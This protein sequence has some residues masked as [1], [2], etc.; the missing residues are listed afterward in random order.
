MKKILLAFI[1]TS[2]MAGS[3]AQTVFTYGKNAV[4]KDEFVRAF[5]KNPSVTG[6]RKKAI[7]E[8]LDLYINFKLK[9]QAA[10]DAGLDTDATQQYELQNFKRQI[11]DNVINDQ[12]NVK[13]LVKEAFSRSQKEIHV[14]HVFV[15][16]IGG[17]TTEAFKRINAAY[18]ELKDGKDFNTVATTYS[19]DEAVRQSKGDLGFVTAFTL[20]YDIE[21]AIYNLKPGSYSTPFKSKLGYHIFRNIEE[22][23]SKGSRRVAQILI[24]LPPNAKPEQRSFAQRKADSIYTLLQAGAN[25]TTLVGEVSN[26][27]ST[28][29]NKGELP[30]FTTGTYSPEFEAAAFSMTKVGEISKPFT[31]EHGFHIIKLLEAN[32]AP[33]DINDGATFA[34]LQ[35]KVSKDTR[36]ERSKQRLI[37][38]K[39]SLLKYKAGLVKLNDVIAYTDSA[40]AGKTATIKGL[41]PNTVLFSFA[42]QN[43]TLDDWIKY[44]KTIPFSEGTKRDYAELYKAYV[45]SA[46]DEYY[47]NNLNDY[48][49]DYAKQLKEFKEANLL[50]GIMEKNVWGKA[51]TD[52]TSLQ[53]YYNHFYC[54]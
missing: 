42:K 31:T 18:K 50:F 21:T 20:P 16:A 4:S 51:N 6:D 1:S 33:T 38:Q 32:N 43:V 54:N 3:Y 48:N 29:S 34:S 44:A 14:A 27:L 36:L 9:V 40:V 30:E 7:K 23:A 45:R 53:E 37:E 13:E 24:S 47:R 52:T 17:D 39:L 25:F 26:D 10:Y 19:S 35:E 28:N 15:E 5:N 12:A 41:A 49:A 46:A 11:A 2:I 8:Y 22:R